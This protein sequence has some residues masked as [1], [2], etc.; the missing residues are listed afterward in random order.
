[1]LRRPV[2]IARRFESLI[3]LF[4]LLSAFNLKAYNRYPVPHVLIGNFPWQSA[5]I[6]A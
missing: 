3:G 5:R 1:M 2:F 6:A 4:R